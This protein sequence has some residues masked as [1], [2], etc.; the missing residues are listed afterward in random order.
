MAEIQTLQLERAGIAGFFEKSFSVDSVKA[1]KPW[2]QTYAHV[3][4]EL[5]AQPSQLCMVACHAWDT[6]GA[7]AAGWEAAFIRRAGNDILG[8]GPQPQIIG[9]DLVDVVEQLIARH[10]AR[11]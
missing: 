4:H 6:L 3:A 8:V 11:R 9:R 1:C 10:I 2:P 5:G 7:V